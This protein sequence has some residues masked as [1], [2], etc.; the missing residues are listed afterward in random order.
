[1]YLYNAAVIM[2]ESAHSEEGGEKWVV[3]GH[4]TGTLVSHRH[5]NSVSAVYARMAI[6]HMVSDQPCHCT[7]HLV[8]LVPIQRY[9]PC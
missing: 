3:E 2:F 9:V 6:M 1:M 4:C 5:G 8:Y 7:F